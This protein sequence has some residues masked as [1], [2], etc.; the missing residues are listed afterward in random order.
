MARSNLH[1]KNCG[2]ESC[3]W[4]K[5][6]HAKIKLHTEI[7]HTDFIID[8]S[9]GSVT[10]VDEMQLTYRCHDHSSYV[11]FN[12][13]VFCYIWRAASDAQNSPAAAVVKNRLTRKTPVL[14]L[15]DAQFKKEFR[16]SNAKLA[17][18]FAHTNRC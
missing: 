14:T 3:D 18:Y 17:T 2:R 9:R 7:Q 16:F 8:V 1:G 15:W 13:H 10:K 5:T 6:L 12:G 4:T 11:R